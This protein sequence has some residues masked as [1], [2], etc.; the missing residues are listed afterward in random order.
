MFILSL[1]WILIGLLI[2]ALANGVRLWPA[3]WGRQGWLYLP[4]AGALLALLGGWLGTLLLG[5]LFGTAT[6][7][8]VAAAGVMV[9]AMVRGNFT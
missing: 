6:A 2:G 1:L 9:C 7:I 5:A 8:L 4:A 3:S